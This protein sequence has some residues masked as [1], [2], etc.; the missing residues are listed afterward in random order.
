MPTSMDPLAI[1]RRL[2]HKLWSPPTEFGPDGWRYRSIGLVAAD[3]QPSESE[4][5][6]VGE[7]LVTCAPQDD[8]VEWLHASIV[9]PWMPTYQDLT[10]LH[11]GVFGDG[12][13]YQVFAPPDQHINIHDR[14]LHLFGRFDGKP[15]LPEFGRYGTI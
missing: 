9:R 14:A 15:A 13:A 6:L 5:R 3:E 11:K 12:Y 10:L 4:Y 1:R 2:G 8:D 7:I